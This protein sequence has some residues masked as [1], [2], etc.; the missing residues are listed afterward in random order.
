MVRFQFTS[1]FS[2]FFYAVCF[3]N[4]VTAAICRKWLFL[5]SICLY[6]ICTPATAQ[7]SYSN[8]SKKKNIT[9]TAPWN[10]AVNSGVFF[11]ELIGVD[12]QIYK[13]KEFNPA[14]GF[15]LERKLFGNVALRFDYAKGKLSANNFKSAPALTDHY[16]A[17]YRQFTTDIQYTYGASLIVNRMLYSSGKFYRSPLILSIWGGAGVIDFETQFVQN[18]DAPIY[19][20]KV[21]DLYQNL[22]VAV[23][24]RYL[25]R[26]DFGLNY[27]MYFYRG[28]NLDAVKVHGGT[29]KDRFSF[30]YVSAH[31]ML[32]KMKVPSK[33][34]CYAY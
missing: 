9:L 19:Y 7:I 31:V 20:G 17:Y 3:V 27:L 5:I 11:T 25:R 30:A 23:R 18:P 14:Y 6:F 22:G 29:H 32:G 33:Q 21:T 34:P 28:Y 1:L 16:H 2:A 26:V 15:S 10:F 13:Q 12:N 8:Y 4:N 24:Y